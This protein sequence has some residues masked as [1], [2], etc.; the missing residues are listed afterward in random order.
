M[1]ESSRSSNVWSDAFVDPI[2]PMAHDECLFSSKESYIEREWVL[3]SRELQSL[4]KL[5]DNW[6]GNG[7]EAP[8][9]E[10]IENAIEFFAFYRESRK[11]SP[12]DRI[13]ASPNGSIVFEWQSADTYMEVEIEEPYTAEWMIEQPGQEAVFL[14]ETW[15]PALS[16]QSVDPSL[17]SSQIY[18]TV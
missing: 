13:V 12:P 11:V 17:F 7:A 14:E 2:S 1:L 18:A 9:P 15:E 5:E 10:L 4:R 8:L 3:R 6:D 16:F